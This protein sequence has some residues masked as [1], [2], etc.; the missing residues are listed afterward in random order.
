MTN[1]DS[2]S[3]NAASDDS[4]EDQ[5]DA[6]TFIN[7]KDTFVLEI[8]DPKDEILAL[9]LRD[10]TPPDGFEVC[11][12]QL[13]PGIPPSRI[14]S[15]AQM[16]TQM[17]QIRYLPNINTKLEFADIFDMLL[18]RICFKLRRLAPCCL[19]DLNFHMEIPDEDE[20]QIAVTGCCLT[21]GEP[22]TQNTALLTLP[23]TAPSSKRASPRPPGTG[24]E[25]MMFNMEVEADK[26]PSSSASVTRTQPPSFNVPGLRQS[27]IYERRKGQPKMPQRLQGVEL[28]P[29]PAVIGGK[30][31]KYLGNYNFFLIRESTSVKECGGLAGFMQCFIGEMMAIVRGH[32]SALGGNAL[33]GYQMSHC[34]L[35]SNLH[36]NQ[37]QC[38]INVCG[39]A[40]QANY[41]N[42]PVS[43]DPLLTA[44]IS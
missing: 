42:E 32:V 40:V 1:G 26:E 9:V 19:T 22:Q 21:L 30:I 23:S 43:A 18:R 33:V 10:S 34:V 31:V 17:A 44:D 35:F 27:K 29:L 36:K 12:T 39:D 28:T 16:F 41:D 6:E 24:Q 7:N 3:L 14:A 38:L 8:D 37:A 15:H 25:E 4:D 2:N 20:V 13:P 11:N 5:S